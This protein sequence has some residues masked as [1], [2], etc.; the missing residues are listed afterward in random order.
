MRF[1]LEIRPLIS[2]AP[3]STLLGRAK[4]LDQERFQGQS[5]DPLHGIP[6]VLKVL[7]VFFCILTDLVL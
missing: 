1:V 4:K 7:V 2:M 6:I 5:R 3:E